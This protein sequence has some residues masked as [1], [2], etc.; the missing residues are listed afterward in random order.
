MKRIYIISILTAVFF[1]GCGK[2]FSVELSLSDIPSDAGYAYLEKSGLISNTIVDSAKVGSGRLRLRAEAPQEPDFYRLRCGGKTLMLAV[3]STETIVLSGSWKDMLSVIAEGSEKTAQLQQ[4]RRSLR[5]ST[6]DAHKRLAQTLILR[7]PKSQTAYYAL[8][9]QKAG[10]TVF[11]INDRDDRRYFQA[12]AT[13]WQVW[14]PDNERTKALCGQV[15]DAINKDRRAQNTEAMKAFIDE[16]EN[17]FLDIILTDENGE[18]R[19]LSELRGKVILL[20]FCSIEIDNYTDYLFSLRERYNTYHSRGLE[21]YQ[22]YPDQN[23]LV[24]EDKVRNLPWTTVRTEN[25]LADIVYKTYNVGVI[26]TLYLINRKG[27]VVKRFNAFAGLN[28]A[29]EKQL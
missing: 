12:V 14:H 24:W 28:E 1:S 4:L 8:Y 23:R 17:S 22:V 21:V 15:I 13:S 10:K 26:P 27:E 6:A 20:D 19:A 3:D 2:R 7:D 29:I 18:E 5:D 25:G 16:S 11:D 9:Q